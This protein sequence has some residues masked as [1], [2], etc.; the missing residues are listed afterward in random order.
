MFRI[1]GELADRLIESAIWHNVHTDRTLIA[2][3][4]LDGMRALQLDC[5][6]RSVQKNVEAP[7]FSA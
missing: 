7:I 1:N 5:L 6:I 4:T 3:N 2:T